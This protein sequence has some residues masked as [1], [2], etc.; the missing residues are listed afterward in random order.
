VSAVVEVM[1]AGEQAGSP[2]AA[3][4]HREVRV[5]HVHSGNLW[6]GVESFLKTLA[7]SDRLVPWMKTE[8]ALCFE[9]QASRE[10]GRAGARVYTLG[11]VRLR[12]PFS[13]RAARR[14]LERLLDARAFDVVVLH[15]AW[16]NALFA[17]V[18]RARR[19]QVVQYVHDTPNRYGW[20]DRWTALVEPQFVIHNSQH[21]EAAGGWWFRRAPHRMIRCPLTIG[22]GPLTPRAELRA[23]LGTPD[24][25]VVIV[26][27]CRMEEWKGHRLLLE[28]LARL[29]VDRPWSC[30]IA[31]KAQRPS[32]RHLEQGLRS[33]VAALGLS[34]RV[35]FLGHRNDVPSLMRA[36]DIHC[37]PNVGPEPFGLAFVEALAAGLPVV[38]TA[39]GGAL[40]IVSSQCG[41]LVRPDAEAVAGALR[42]LLLEDGRRRALAAAG[43]ARARELCDP[44]L[45][46]RRLADALSQVA[47]R[48]FA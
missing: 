47:T 4:V 2:D 19:L 5:L 11:A 30:W 27:A 44:A 48:D 16:S 38:T 43:P 3:P 9:G 18:A 37:Q 46:I 12:N 14:S 33:R 24:D 22:E 23:S 21:T 31:G 36:A 20:L 45:Q 26:S 6:G 10:L 32:E 8:F 41:I 7:V 13:V 40:E 28:A 34:D 42:S 17:R 1:D 25:A 39:M 15:S 35:K 29:R